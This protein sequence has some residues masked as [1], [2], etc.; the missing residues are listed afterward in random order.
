MDE[1][2]RPQADGGHALPGCYR[3]P[4]RETGIA[5]ARCGRPICPDCMVDASV[6]FQ[7]P[8]C[9]RGAQQQVRQATTPF[10]G[11][12]VR[13][14]AL[15]TKVLIGLNLLVFVFTA[16]IRPE[17]QY[18]LELSSRPGDSLYLP[19]GVVAGEWYR[20][21]SAVFVHYGLLHIVMNMVSLWVLGPQ[22]EAALGRLRYLALYLVSGV[23]GNAL[24]YLVA[25]GFF[26]SAGASG[27]IFGLLGATAVLFRV[28][29]RPVGPVIALLV[30]NLVITFSVP[31]ID[32]RAHIGGL[33]AG[34]AMAAGM[35][36]APRANRNLLQGLTVA[37]VLGAAVLLVVVRTAQQG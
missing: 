34:T 7:C 24:V 17:W 25:P 35:M 12:P 3:H 2:A 19:Y 5:C 13:D 4:D 32:W 6:G 20:L 9:V 21:V 16:Y 33:V 15:V 14:P 8:D 22:L 26:E 18:D 37:A 36:Y 27:A 31:H 28:Y 29:R 1:Q 23:A 11:R 10:G 30:F